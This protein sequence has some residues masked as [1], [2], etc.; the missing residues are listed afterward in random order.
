MSSSLSDIID[1]LLKISLL[2]AL[3]CS[4]FIFIQAIIF[5]K[6]EYKERFLSWQMPMIIALLTELYLLSN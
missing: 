5:K 1:I 6:Y 4:V 2:V 3:G